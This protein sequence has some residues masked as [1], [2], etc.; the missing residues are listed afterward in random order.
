LT[1]TQGTKTGGGQSAKPVNAKVSFVIGRDTSPIVYT[2]FSGD[3]TI[4]TEMS[5]GIDIEI[6]SPD[7]YR[8]SLVK[9]TRMN[10]P[11][12]R[13]NGTKQLPKKVL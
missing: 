4:K 2:T 12:I 9:K 5:G 13:Q 8:H 11:A 1:I 3:Y 10:E 7:R 6:A